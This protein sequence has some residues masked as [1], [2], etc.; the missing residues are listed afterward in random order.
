MR[1]FGGHS[2]LP[3]LVP[4]LGA[5]PVSLPCSP[6]KSTLWL[7]FSGL[8]FPG[9]PSCAVA[10]IALSGEVAE[11]PSLRVLPVGPLCR[12]QGAPERWE[13]GGEGPS[14]EYRLQVLRSGV[15]LG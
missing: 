5:T 12:K 10:A 1:C 8:S 13:M 4:A 14:S 15:R 11:L 6:R 3:S 7:M 9:L 2:C